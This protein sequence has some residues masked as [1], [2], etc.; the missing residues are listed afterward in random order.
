MPSL[1]TEF[2][3]FA[4]NNQFQENCQWIDLYNESH[5]INATT[6][7]ITSKWKIFFLRGLSAVHL[8]LVDIAQ[9]NLFLLEESNIPQTDFHSCNTHSLYLRA[10]ILSLMGDLNKAQRILVMLLQGNNRLELVN[11][12]YILDTLGKLHFLKGEFYTA[13]KYLLQINKSSS[14]TL[15][16][17]T[18]YLKLYMDSLQGQGAL[19][20]QHIEQDRSFSKHR[21]PI[22]DIYTAL[23]YLSVHK[24]DIAREYLIRSITTRSLLQGEDLFLLQRAKFKFHNL[25]KNKKMSL[26]ILEEYPKHLFIGKLFYHVDYLHFAE[27]HKVRSEAYRHY[28]LAIDLMTESDAEELIN[29]LKRLYKNKDYRYI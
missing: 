28:C 6:S 12:A 5:L 3:L 20:I 7:S 21:Q 18:T 10:S 1:T 9:Q 16:A 15:K 2:S 22:A 27:V 26:S 29:R 14:K 25:L 24:V 4:R 19:A 23:I 11:E 13:K 17:R 8:G